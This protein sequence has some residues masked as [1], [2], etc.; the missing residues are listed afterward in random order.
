MPDIKPAMGIQ[1]SKGRFGHCLNGSISPMHWL[2]H[3]HIFLS[4]TFMCVT[5]AILRGQPWQ[6]D[7]KNRGGHFHSQLTDLYQQA[8]FSLFLVITK[9]LLSQKAQVLC[10]R[11]SL[12]SILLLSISQDFFALRPQSEI[13]IQ[14]YCS[15]H[16]FLTCVHEN[17]SN[18]QLLKPL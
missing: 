16:L 14:T 15:F 8:P 5:C 18:S 10:F 13:F 11:Q 1:L 12:V 6:T 17:T 3:C 4:Y 7:S 2:R 9:V